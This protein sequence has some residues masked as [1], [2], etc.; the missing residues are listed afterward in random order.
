[1]VEEETHNITTEE[2]AQQSTTEENNVE[3]GTTNEEQG[4]QSDDDGLVNYKDKYRNLKRK[5]K[6]LLFEQE[7]FHEELRKV[8]RK[9]LRV[10]RDKSFLLDHLLK[11]EEPEN[12]SADDEMTES[13]ENE[14]ETTTK[15][16]IKKKKKISRSK[17]ASKSSDA[18]SK[19]ALL[20]GDKVRCRKV[21][22]G[23]QCSKLVSTVV[24]SGICYA[25]RQ[26]LSNEK[27]QATS[28]IKSA[29]SP[30]PTTSSENQKGQPPKGGKDIGQIREAMEAS[31]RINSSSPGLPPEEDDELVID[32]PL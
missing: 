1:M 29:K 22:N 11:Y 12:S 9:C 24:K 13:S 18:K 17:E 15:P 8:Q 16:P 19:N 28:P 3:N 6:C 7:C 21:E 4:V 10:N 5:L 23:K 31:S 27:P 30:V 32:I 20:A 14:E 26:Q 2:D 25:H